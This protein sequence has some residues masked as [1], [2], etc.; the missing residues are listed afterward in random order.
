MKLEEEPEAELE[1]LVSTCAYFTTR[2]RAKSREEAHVK[3]LNQ[4]LDQQQF[5]H[6]ETDYVLEVRTGKIWYY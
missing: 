3:A 5:D 4:D 6:M 1:Y 2:V